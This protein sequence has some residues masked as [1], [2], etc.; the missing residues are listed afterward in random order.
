MGNW[1]KTVDGA[2][3]HSSFSD[4]VI[5]MSFSEFQIDETSGNVFGTSELRIMKHGEFLSMKNQ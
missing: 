1:W 4:H 5:G 3:G 2:M